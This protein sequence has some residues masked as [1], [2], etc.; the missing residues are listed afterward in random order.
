MG[1]Y[2]MAVL[3][4]LDFIPSDEGHRQLR[5]AFCAIARSLV[6]PLLRVQDGESGLWYQVLN[7]PDREGNY[8]EA[9][10]SAMFVY[11]FL[12][13]MSK[14]YAEKSLAPVMR[15]SALRAYDGILGQKITEE[16]DGELHLHGV[17]GSAGLGVAPGGNG[18]YRDGSFEYY[19][20]EPLVTDDPKGVGPL[21]LA[22]LYREGRI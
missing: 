14:G 16:A 11:F 10:A 12:K 21:I 22:S 2:C 20:H 19:V 8:L 15:E 1:W 4:V 9:S 17:C 13:M 7:F 6:A 5:E 3:D 18:A